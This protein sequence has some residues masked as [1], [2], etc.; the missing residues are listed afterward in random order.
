MEV[1]E[2]GWDP[3]TDAWPICNGGCGMVGTMPAVG[4]RAR[5]PE[6]RMTPLPPLTAEP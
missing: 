3:G 1:V 5:R 2:D 6:T 4:L